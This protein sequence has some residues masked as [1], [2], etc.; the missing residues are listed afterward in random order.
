[1]CP[2]TSVSALP[3]CNAGAAGQCLRATDCVSRDTF[4]SGGGSTVETVV[5]SGSAWTVKTTTANP[6]TQRVGTDA[7]PHYAPGGTYP[8]GVVVR[9]RVETSTSCTGAQLG[10]PSI[11][12]TP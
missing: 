8:I 10:T 12:N 5:C 1:M 9:D 4:T 11:T 2:P 6:T 7:L 3:P